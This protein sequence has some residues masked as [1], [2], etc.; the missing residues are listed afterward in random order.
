MKQTLFSLKFWFPRFEVSYMKSL[1][2]DIDLLQRTNMLFVLF[3][4]YSDCI[5]KCIKIIHENSGQFLSGEFGRGCS[6]VSDS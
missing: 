4:F 1:D 6:F 5:Q 2:P 3:C